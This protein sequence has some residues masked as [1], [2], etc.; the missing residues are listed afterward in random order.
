M[1]QM[2]VEVIAYF[3]FCMHSIVI[4]WFVFALLS[5]FDCKYSSIELLI[6]LSALYNLGWHYKY[7]DAMIDCECAMTQISGK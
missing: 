3:R 7:V 6:M 1:V 4:V 2:H 5:S